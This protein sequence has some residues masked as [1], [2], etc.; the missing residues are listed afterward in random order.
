MSSP[1]VIV[2]EL[3][4][5]ADP[6][7]DLA[8]HGLLEFKEEDDRIDFKVSFDPSS[9]RSWIDLAVDCAAFANTNGGYIIVGVADKTWECAGIAPEAALALGDTKQLLERINRGLVPPLTRARSRVFERDGKVF[10][11]IFVPCNHEATHIFESNLDWSPVPGK[12]LPLIRKGAIYI[13]RSASNHLVTSA[14][15]EELLQ[16]RLKRFRDKVLEGMA[17]VVNAGPG[18]EVVTITHDQD[19]SRMPVV[20][21]KDGPAS[22]NLGGRPLKLAGNSVAE[23]ISIFRGLTD[24]DAQFSVPRQTTLQCYVARETAEL[25]DESIEWLAHHSLVNGSPIFWWLK[26]LGAAKSKAVL[27]RAFKVAGRIQK[28]HIVTYAGF[29]G[30]RFFREMAEQL[31]GK[32]T[33]RFSGKT[34]LLHV[35]R[36]KHPAD[37]ALQAT[38]LAKALARQSDAQKGYELEKL[39][40]AL[41]APFD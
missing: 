38:N 7:S 35:H 22:L 3:L 13:R 31:D 20:T 39:D 1:R 6:L 30:E 27:R 21:I 16:R 18:Q 8:C 25:D 14:D 36:S 17:R 26:K 15:F 37:D 4:D 41:Y 9:E 33:R 19:S 5:S 23:L 29:W 10:T 24:A 32:T 28:E 40:C 2:P 34:N 12:T 11:A